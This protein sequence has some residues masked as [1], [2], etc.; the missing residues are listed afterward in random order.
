[1]SLTLEKGSTIFNKI[2]MYNRFAFA[3]LN[4]V[5]SKIEWA[6]FWGHPVDYSTYF[7]TAF[8]VQN[9]KKGI[10]HFKNKIGRFMDQIVT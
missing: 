9:P 6:T 5:L 3:N 2:G 1:M 4:F 10:F 7:S 8:L